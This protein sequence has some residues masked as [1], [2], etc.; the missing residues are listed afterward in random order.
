MA[1]TRSR[2]RL[3]RS[4][5]DKS[6]LDQSMIDSLYLLGDVVAVCYLFYWSSKQDAG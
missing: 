1:D 2:R 4:H 5:V 6:G 3:A